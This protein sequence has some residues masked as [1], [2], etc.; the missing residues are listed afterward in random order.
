M[1]VT[2]ARTNGTSLRQGSISRQYTGNHSHLIVSTFKPV[3]SI[4][5]IDYL[6]SN[7][8]FPYNVGDRYD[9]IKFSLIASKKSSGE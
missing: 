6:K 5:C 8:K 7:K 4:Q 3:W 2:E 9:Y 1:K